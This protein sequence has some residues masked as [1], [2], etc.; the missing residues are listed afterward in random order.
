MAMSAKTWFLMGLLTVLGG[1]NVQA[2][3]EDP[4]LWLE[5][6]E[7]EKA[8]AWAKE[9]N[10]KSAE[11]KRDDR[12]GPIHD[13]LLEIYNSDDRIPHV[14]IRGPYLY[15][16]WQ[17]EVNKRGLW[18]RTT[19][20]EY[21]KPDPTWE[22]MVDVDSLSQAEDE[23]W[24]FKGTTYLE[25]NFDRVILELSRGGA[26][27]VVMREFDT[28]EKAF[29]EDG[30]RLE[31]AK[32]GVSWKDKNTLYVGTDFGSDTK[33][34]SGYPRIAKI[35]RRG[36]SLENADTVL[37]GEK[38]DVSIWS[39]VIVSPERHYDIIGRSIEFYKTEIFTIEHGEL[40]RID[41]PLDA[42]LITVFKG[43]MLVRLKSDW[44]VNE[45][46]YTQGSLIAIDYDRFLEGDRDFTIVVEPDERKSIEDVG[47]TRDLLLVNMLMNVRSELFEYTFEKGSWSH[48][49]VDTPPNG[50]IQLGGQDEH[51]NRYFFYYEGFV[52]PRSLF[53]VG[54]GNSAPVV[55]KSLPDF[56]DSE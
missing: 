19:F 20:D 27:A 47:R 51:S 40:V 8:L 43:Q 11:L 34:D 45:E 28:V 12:F 38:T 54:E 13:R 1:G 46:T 39:S 23:D 18:R 35:W 21:A 24:V 2:V 26:D 25:P 17:D 30:F 41:I 10:A 3:E 55:V 15:N 16:F 53:F 6:V 9:Q 50:T 22:T 7:S 29:V 5:E 44:E 32:S 56:F 4:Y 52:K 31:E 14:S 37:E 49:Q 48:R 36:Q 42:N 33:T